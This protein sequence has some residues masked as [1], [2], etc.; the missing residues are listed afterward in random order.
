[1]S[2]GC[3]R[4]TGEE[5][6]ADHGEEP[7]LLPDAEGPHHRV[8]FTFFKDHSQQWSYSCLSPQFL[9]YFLKTKLYSFI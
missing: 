6:L 5:R 1:M 4:R 8:W 7:T 9:I 2:M 3:G